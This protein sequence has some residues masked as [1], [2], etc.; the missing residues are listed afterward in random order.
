[1]MTNW[2][3]MAKGTKG[4]A[5]AV[6]EQRAE[7][8]VSKGLILDLKNGRYRVESRS[9]PGRYYD[10]N[11]LCDWT[12]TCPYHAARR[13]YCKHI[14]AVQMMVMRAEP[15]VPT[16]FVIRKPETRCTNKKCGSTDCKIYQ[17]R[18]RKM[19]GVSIRYRCTKCRNRFTYRPG[20][21][22]RHYPDE[23]VS[24][25]LDDVN[26]GRSLAGAARAVPKNSH[27]G[28]KIGEPERSTV[29]RWMRDAGASVEKVTESAPIRTCGRWDAD[30]IY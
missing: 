5:Q 16:D 14:I 28:T 2:S 15:L 21:L 26:E 29:L 25:A 13:T 12:C 27:T 18:K 1:M 10:V 6:L 8:I 23:T 22:G 3:F 30:E 17:G 24:R 7:G 9:E 11:F 4:S 19:G 20:F